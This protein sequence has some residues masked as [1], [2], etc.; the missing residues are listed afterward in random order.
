MLQFCAYSLQDKW[1]LVYNG[2]NN[3]LATF[4][5]FSQRLGTICPSHQV[6]Q[7]FEGHD[8][9]LNLSIQVDAVSHYDDTI[10]Q[11]LCSIQKSHQLVGQPRNG[12]RLSR[13][14]RVLNQESLPYT[15]SFCLYQQ[16][17]YT[18]QLMI[19]RPYHAY[20]LRIRLGVKSFYYLSIVLD[21]VT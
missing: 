1:E 14:C 13:T 16:F 12:V 15:F 20:F 9:V 19:A 11:R 7:A 21:D 4:Q 3:L 18:I 2:D 6:L 10:Q 8:V 5:M 17:S